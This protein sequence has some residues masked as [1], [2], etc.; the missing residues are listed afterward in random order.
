MAGLLVEKVRKN[1][2]YTVQFHLLKN[3]TYLLSIF[4]TG[5]SY[6]HNHHLARRE[7]QRPVEEIGCLENQQAETHYCVNMHLLWTFTEQAATK[8]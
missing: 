1:I 6:R 5:G 4:L 7:P 3:P 2:Q 8:H